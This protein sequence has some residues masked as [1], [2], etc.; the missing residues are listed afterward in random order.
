MF[1]LHRGGASGIPYLEPII[2]ITFI[3]DTVKINL[4]IVNACCL[5]MISQIY[6]VIRN[7]RGN[8]LLQEDLIS[9]QEW[10][11]MELITI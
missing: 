8:N 10:C 5:Q 11:C 2:F 6:L 1:L 7:A 9:L 4:N 3:Y